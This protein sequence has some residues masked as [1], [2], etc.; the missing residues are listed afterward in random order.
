MLYFNLNQ[1]LSCEYICQKLQKSIETFIKKNQPDL[2]NYQLV[3]SIQPVVYTSDS[4]I[5]KLEYQSLDSV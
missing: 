3:I 1:P 5:P 4:L 2:N